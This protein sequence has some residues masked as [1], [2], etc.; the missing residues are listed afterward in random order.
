MPLVINSPGSDA[1]CKYTHMHI[2]NADKAILRNQ[3]R[4]LAY[5]QH[6]P[7]LKMQNMVFYS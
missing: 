2:N 4:A 1:T 7:G 5:G 6:T 3:V